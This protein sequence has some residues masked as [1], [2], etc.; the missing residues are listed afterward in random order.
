VGIY[1]E[2]S[3][4]LRLV[5]ISAS[6]SIDTLRTRLGELEKNTK[7]H[8]TTT[9]TTSSA[10][11]AE[12]GQGVFFEYVSRRPSPCYCPRSLVFFSLL[13]FYLTIEGHEHCRADID[14][15]GIFSGLLPCLED[16]IKKQGR[17]HSC[18]FSHTRAYRQS[19]SRSTPSR[20]HERYGYWAER[21]RIDETSLESE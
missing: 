3:D 9:T 6:S 7:K 16:T 2:A 10:A 14:K 5:L 15:S 13:R 8:T 19:W 1:D 18:L 11:T 21:P 4:R 12:H 17:I 20:R